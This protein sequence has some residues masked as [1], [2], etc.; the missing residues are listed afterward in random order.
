MSY[1]SWQYI[2]ATLALISVMPVVRAEVRLPSVLASHMVIQRDKPV[3]IWG[4]AYPGEQVTVRFRGQEGTAVANDLGRWS[5]YLPPE[6]AGGPFSLIIEG[7]N[8]ITLTDVLVGD[9]WIASGQS[10]MEMP[11]MKTHFWRGVLNSQQEIDAANYPQLRLY[12]V[13]HATSDYPM[14]DAAAETWTACTP[15]SVANFSGTAYFFGRELLKMEKV[16]IG[17]IETDWGGTPAEA[18]TS[19]GALASDSSLMP[20][21]AAQAHMEQN[22]A[23][24]MFRLRVKREAQE[25]AKTEGSTL[26]A[27]VPHRSP[28]FRAPAALFNA[29]VMPLTPL[30]IRGVIW[31]QGASNS[32]PDRAFLYSRLFPALIQDWRRHWAQGNFP[33]IFVQLANFSCKGVWAT[34][35][36]PTVRESQRKTLSLVDTGMA[37]TIDVGDSNN[38][39]PRDKQDVGHRLAL[40]A[41][42]LAYGEH[43]EDSGPLFRQAVPEGQSIRIWFTHTGGGL[44]AKG[45]ELRSFEVAGAD[46]KFRPAAAKVDGT[47]VIVSSAAVR[48]PVYVRYGWSPDPKCNLYNTE[49]LPA[50]PFTSQD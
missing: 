32:D 17:L 8:T 3:H 24:T 11:M 31:D 4:D 39:H 33:F 15:Q 21:F 50:S 34:S 20:V 14:S 40:W 1:M 47:T 30:P 38:V 36:W 10:N 19:L 7:K 44:V 29:M 46:G 23:T 16:P 5:V 49:G 26:P 43:I 2:L 13:K 27:D 37:V 12:H 48:A 35:D 18:W 42:V 9:I 45:G 25:S 28:D 41:R 22:E 6:G